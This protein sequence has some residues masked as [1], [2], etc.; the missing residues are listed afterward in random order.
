M[1]ARKIYIIA[2]ASVLVLG[3]TALIVFAG[4]KSQPSIGDIED[5]RFLLD[6]VVSIRIYESDDND[7][8][9]SAFDLIESHEATLS[10]Y[11]NKSE[12]SAINSS[13]AGVA[14]AVSPATI[15]VIMK[16]KK[17]AEM[18]AGA[19]DPT[20]GPLVDLWG[21]GGPSPQVPTQEEIE[22]ALS[23][24]DYRQ[25]TVDP[26]SLTVMLN[27]DGM[28]LDLGGI[29]KGW[30]ADEVSRFLQ[31]GGAEHFLIN[32]G[33]NVLVHGDKPDGSPFR[34]GMQDPAA[35]R[36]RYMGIY[37]L[38]NGSVVS[39]GV[40]ERYFEAEGVRYHH[41]LS[42]KDGR[43]VRNGLAAVTI[44]SDE[45]IDG[46][47]LS[48]TVFALGLEAGMDLVMGLNGVEAAFV[49]EAGRVILTQGAADRFKPADSDLDMEIRPAG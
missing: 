37:T 1:S 41:I 7:L 5:N 48:T 31:E 20:V 32:L 34:I 13:P 29:A 23:F 19:F 33:G 17:Y 27:Q 12:V 47:A 22:G 6:T 30:I 11:N 16:A 39:S 10:R 15:G 43:P 26:D 49:T 28:T 18:S 38:D 24:V 25:M 46:D 9:N 35:D 36:G 42:T 21:I 45:S 3:M 8:L 44:L 2:A 40:Y 14:V 4:P